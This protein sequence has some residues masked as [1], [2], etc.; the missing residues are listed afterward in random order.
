[1]E[2]YGTLPDGQTVQRVTLTNACGLT[3][4]LITYGARLTELWV[5]GRDGTLADI[6]LGHDTLDAYLASTTFF[7][8]TCG[9]YANRIARGRFVLDGHP[10]QLDLNEGANHL[11]GGP[12]GFDRKNWAITAQDGSSVTFTTGSDDGEMGYPGA[13]DLTTTYSLTDDNRMTVTMTGTTT[14]PTVMNMVNHAYFNLAGQGSGDV[15]G[16]TI[17][18]SARSYT[19]VDAELLP[20]GDIRGVAGTPFDFRSARPIGQDFARLGAGSRGYDHNWCLSHADT[21][22][23]PCAIATDP[24][25]GRRLTLTTTEPGVQFYTGGHVADGLI[26]KAG[27][28]LCRNAGFTLETQKYP[29]SPNWPQFPSSRLDPSQTYR[30]QMQFTFDTL[31]A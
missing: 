26:G 20:T 9:R 18:I 22:L 2:V 1:M 4:R 6:V 5:P 13:C 14:R 11:H 8:A 7:G 10:V 28:P 12:L 29:D 17:Q 27:R 25:S 30:H 21:A 15:L 16:Q 24:V 31:P 19:P 3:A 23:R